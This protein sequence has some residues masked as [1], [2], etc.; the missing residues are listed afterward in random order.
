MQKLAWNVESSCDIVSGILI[1]IIINVFV[2]IKNSLK[3]WTLDLRFLFL[4]VFLPLFASI[5]MLEMLT[6]MEQVTVIIEGN[7]C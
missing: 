3:P 7:W 4:E 5:K 1:F 2:S 6:I